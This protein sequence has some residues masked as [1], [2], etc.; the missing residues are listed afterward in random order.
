[1]SPAL[2]IIDDRVTFKFG[3]ITTM[4]VDAVVNAAKR[5]LRR[6]G[7]VSGA[8]FAAAAR[9]LADECR[10]IAPCPVGK[11]VLTG[12]HGLPSRRIIHAVGPMWFGGFFGEHYRLFECYQNTL[13]LADQHN[14]KTI[15][16]PAISTGHFLYPT[17]SAA[18]IAMRAIRAYFAE[19]ESD[20]ETVVLCFTDPKKMAIYKAAFGASGA[21]V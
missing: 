3:D 21:R 1:M 2:Q 10:T 9:D 7:G 18:R 14:L 13:H 15:A 20:I 12:S 4:H 19:C 11:A 8:V 6:G 5:S 16:I 17:R